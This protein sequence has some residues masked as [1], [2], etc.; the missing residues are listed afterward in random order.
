MISNNQLRFSAQSPTS[1]V[2]LFSYVQLD[3]PRMTFARVLLAEV[4]ARQRD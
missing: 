2:D 1:M 4:S 3:A